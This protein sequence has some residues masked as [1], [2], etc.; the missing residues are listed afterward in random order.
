[1]RGGEAN[2]FPS[3]AWQSECGGAALLPRRPTPKH[4]KCHYVP[5]QTAALAMMGS[6]PLAAPPRTGWRP[7]VTRR[8]RPR[9]AFNF[10]Q[11]GAARCVPRRQPR[12][13]WALVGAGAASRI[14]QTQW[15]RFCHWTLSPH[16]RA[17]GSD[18]T[19]SLIT[20]AR[21]CYLCCLAVIDPLF[22]F[23]PRAFMFL[24][25]NESVQ[26]LCASRPCRS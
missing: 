17:S 5:W 6:S 4:F 21:G 14:K 7:R 1:M 16:H 26:C 9:G 18:E 20:A 25:R 2:N 11:N 8:I 15:R 23:Y 10:C 19:P 12:A 13:N 24:I 3:R 22:L